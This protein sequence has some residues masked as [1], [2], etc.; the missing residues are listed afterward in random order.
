MSPVYRKYTRP[1]QSGRRETV[2][3]I[4]TV[5]IKYDRKRTQIYPAHPVPL[6]YMNK[7]DVAKL[8]FED[9]EDEVRISKGDKWTLIRVVGIVQNKPVKERAGILF[10]KAKKARASSNA[11]KNNRGTRRGGVR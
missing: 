5:E 10:P 6:G 1:V 11:R 2:V 4:C 9:I 8:T 3:A 7:S